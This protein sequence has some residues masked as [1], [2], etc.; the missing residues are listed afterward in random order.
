ML[1][2]ADLI[3][4]S[5]KKKGLINARVKEAEGAVEEEVELQMVVSQKLQWSLQCGRS[6][7]DVDPVPAW[8][9]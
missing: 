6:I 2:L 3:T 8:L 9:Y 5:E 4:P 7:F 1:N